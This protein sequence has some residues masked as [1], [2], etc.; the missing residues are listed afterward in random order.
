M[1][2]TRNSGAVLVADLPYRRVAGSDLC[3]YR[4]R[5]GE[6]DL[7]LATT[8]RE[9]A[10][11]GALLAEAREIIVSYLETTPTFQR[12][13]TPLP[14]DPTAP[15]LVA[16]LL[17]GGIAAGVG[18]MAAIA[19]AIAAFVGGRLASPEVIVENGGDLYLKTTKVR[20]VALFAGQDSAL[21]FRLGLVID[22]A[23]TP[24]GVCTSS[25]TFGHALSFGTADA[26]TITSPNCAIADAAAT[27]VANKV[28]GPDS[29]SDALAFAAQIPQVTGAVIVK[30]EQL[31]AWGDVELVKL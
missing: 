21:S 29:V 9:E 14:Q 10:L 8:L 7:A 2:Q 1:P 18:P 23:N 11:A 16:E 31:G 19:G 26:V 24:L 27:A 20:R 3:S 25:G 13:L 22:P 30:D 17:R 28:Q 4:I 5:Q 15:P 12:S 6:S